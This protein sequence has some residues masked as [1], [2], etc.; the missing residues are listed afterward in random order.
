M[1][2]NMGNA[3]KIVRTALAA[4]VFLLILTGSLEG[5]WAWILGIFAVVFLA[6]SAVGYCPLYQAVKFS[7]LKTAPGGKK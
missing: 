5:I 7:T 3:D 4:I 6:T 1:T 2:K